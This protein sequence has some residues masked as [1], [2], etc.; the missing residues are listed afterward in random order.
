MRKRERSLFTLFVFMALMV[1]SFVNCGRPSKLPGDSNSLS[2]SG[3]KGMSFAL[4]NEKI[5]QPK[6]VMC[7]Q[8]FSNYSTLMAS[9]V[10]ISKKPDQSSLYLKTSSGQMPKGGSPLSGEEVN[11]IYQWISDGA[12]E[13]V[14]SLP[15]GSIPGGT[16]PGGTTPGGSTPGGT[17]PPVAGV[18]PTYEWIQNNVFI[19]RCIICHRGASAPSGYDLTSFDNV[20]AGGRVNPGN[21]STS[22]LFQRIDN[23]SM[24]PGGPALSAEVKQAV[25]KWIENGAKND[26]PAPGSPGSGGPVA[27]PPPLPPLGPTFA[28]I[29]ANIIQPRCLGCHNSTNRTA[30]VSLEGYTNLMRYVR[31]GRSGSS[32]L[33]EVI[34][35]NE[36]PASGPA[37]SAQQKTVIRQWIDAGAQNN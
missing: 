29:N 33:Y 22:R 20:M 13:T 36:M 7:H 1:V 19:P 21:P 27:T 25:A 16:P 8:N 5:L 24:P 6:C 11:A 35:D 3:S 37:L 23:N 34:E 28:S 14:A 12:P 10:V 17:P 9:G 4:I 18:S 32:E 31:A 26:A 30:G 15:S 2:S